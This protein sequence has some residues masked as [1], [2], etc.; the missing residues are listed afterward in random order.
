MSR[1][2]LL[3]WIQLFL[4]NKNLIGVQKMLGSSKSKTKLL[5][6]LAEAGWNPM[7][8]F[9]TVE[10]NSFFLSPQHSDFQPRTSCPCQPLLSHSSHLSRGSSSMPSS[11]PG[12]EGAV[13][14]KAKP[15]AGQSCSEGSQE[16]PH[17]LGGVGAKSEPPI[18]ETNHR[19]FSPL[20]DPNTCKDR[21]SFL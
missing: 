3:L 18:A 2:R 15:R 20:T 16:G 14:R 21:F 10:D 19:I 13:D 6:M 9:F 7:S 12:T 11:G 8:R 1:D 5:L 17:Q 4:T